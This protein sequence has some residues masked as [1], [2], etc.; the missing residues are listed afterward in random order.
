MLERLQSKRICA[1]VIDYSFLL[2]NPE[3]FFLWFEKFP[4][5]ELMRFL[6]R[7]MLLPTRK[8][9]LQILNFLASHALRPRLLDVWQEAEMVWHS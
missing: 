6:G 9:E 1:V 7:Q 4:S 5:E 3:T 8:V 2:P